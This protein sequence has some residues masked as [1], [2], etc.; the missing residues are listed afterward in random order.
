MSQTN[1]NTD[2]ADAQNNNHGDENDYIHR[3]ELVSYNWNTE[4]EGQY[5]EITRFDAWNANITWHILDDTQSDDVLICKEYQ[6]PP[7][8]K[9]CTVVDPNST[10][11]D[12]TLRNPED[13]EGGI[14]D[15]EAHEDALAQASLLD[16]L[17]TEQI[18]DMSESS[19]VFYSSYNGNYFTVSFE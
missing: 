10:D 9:V 15:K 7:E 16:L 8:Y 18:E 17:D 3:N 12:V 13:W 11:F 14:S 6:H 2:V 1:D 4:K 5:K 19:I